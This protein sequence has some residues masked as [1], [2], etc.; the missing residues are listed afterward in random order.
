MRT[1]FVAFADKDQKQEINPI[2]GDIYAVI[3]QVFFSLST[4]LMNKLI[5]NSDPD[6][7]WQIYFALMGVFYLI[8]L[9]PLFFIFIFT[10]IEIFEFPSFHNLLLILCFGFFNCVLSDFSLNKSSVLLG[11]L[12]TD[13]G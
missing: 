5:P 2:L 11:S 9:F 7:D 13:M 6:F 1:I 8:G 12:I 4:V 3:A 10:G